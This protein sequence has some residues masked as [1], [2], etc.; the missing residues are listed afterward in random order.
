MRRNLRTVIFVENDKCHH[1]GPQSLQALCC[2]GWRIRNK[3]EQKRI[4]LLHLNNLV[5]LWHSIQKEPRVDANRLRILNHIIESQRIDNNY[6][7]SF[8]YFF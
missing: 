7:S 8:K 5:K 2:G 3:S 4:L 6:Y 1:T